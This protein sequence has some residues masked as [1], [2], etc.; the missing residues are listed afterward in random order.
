MILSSKYIL[1]IVCI[2]IGAWVCL[3]ILMLHCAV[4]VL[5]Y[6]MALRHV[7]LQLKSN[8]PSLIWPLDAKFTTGYSKA[9]HRLALKLYI[10]NPDV[11]NEL[12]AMHRAHLISE[13]KWLKAA[14]VFFSASFLILSAGCFLMMCGATNLLFIP[15]LV[16]LIVNTAFYVFAIKYTKRIFLVNQMAL[17]RLSNK[18]R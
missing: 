9:K 5:I 10:I 2:L 7:F 8:D 13:K 16:M 3:V 14:K 1:S 18:K 11:G 17:Y 4:R 12:A 15:P 6:T